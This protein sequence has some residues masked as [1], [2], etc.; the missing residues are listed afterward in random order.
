MQREGNTVLKHARRATI[1]LTTSALL[2]VGLTTGPAAHAAS[3]DSD[4]ATEWLAGQ[5]DGGLLHQEFN[6][7]VYPQYGPSLDVFFTFM[8]LETQ[9]EA[10]QSILDAVDQDLGSYI[11]SGE[12]SY[13]GPTAKFLTAVQ[14]AGVSLEDYG[15]GQLRP[16]LKALVV[17]KRG[18][19]FGRVM[20]DS[21][22]GDYSNTLTQSWSVRAFSGWG[23]KF[24]GRTTKY[25]L[26]QQCD[27]GYFRESMKGRSCE[28]G[29]AKDNSNPSVDATA[30]AVLALRDAKRA[31]VEG[32]ADDIRQALKWLVRNQNKNG[33]FTGNGVPNAN[34]T[35]LAGWVLDGTKWD[36][37]AADAARWLRKMQLTEA[38]TAGTALEGEAGAVAYNR[39][40]LQKGYD[41]GITST[42]GIEWALAT[43]QAAVALDS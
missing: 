1:A 36:G 7:T 28:A 19:K 40:A 37:A 25:L 35:G 2:T 14:K 5:L 8:E 32:L 30:L 4:A 26:K 31:G 38:G 43:A 9:P 17:T 21:A 10:G 41:E 13:A 39:A 27:A 29:L 15:D 3:A 33:S 6:G 11:G 23:H 22:Y 16:R 42:T 18:A 20:D 24:M 12:E 34:S